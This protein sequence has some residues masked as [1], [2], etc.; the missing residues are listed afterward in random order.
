MLRHCHEQRECQ[1]GV[2][3]KKTFFKTAARR[4]GCEERRAE[5]LTFTVFPELRDRLTRG[6]AAHVDAQLVAAVFATLQELLG[7]PTGIEGEA[8]DVMS[9]LPKDLKKLWLGAHRRLVEFQQI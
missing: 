9:Q 7:S 4:V 2:C 8:W 5:A 6:E 3:H 1:R